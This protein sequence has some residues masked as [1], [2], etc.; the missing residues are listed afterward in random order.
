MTSQKVS[1]DQRTAVL[2]VEVPPEEFKQSLQAAH[3]KNARHFQVP[4]FRKGKAPY[5]VVVRHYGEDI[6]YDDAL[7]IALPKA[8]GQAL[9]EHEIAPF[10]DPRFNVKEISG[11]SGLVFEVSVALKP[12][13]K[14]GKYEGLEAYR[15][16][17]EVEEEAVDRKIEEAR[18]RVSRLVPVTDRPVEE[19]DRVTID[20]K[21]FRGE[22]AF[23][24]GE[25]E[26]HQLEI[27]SGS[28]IPGFE[29]GLIGRSAGDEFDLPLTFPETYQ[30]EDLAGQDVVFKVKIHEILVKELPEIDDEFVR[31][32]SDSCDTVEEY[33]AEIREELSREMNSQADQAFE[34]NI[35]DKIV[36]GSAIELSDLIVEDE[37]DRAIERQE[38]QFAM[39]GLS[40]RDFLQYSGQTP[41][42][43]RAGQARKSRKLIESAWVVETIR[44]SEKERFELSEEEFEKA[45]GEAAEEAGVS[46][47]LFR[48]QYLKSDH[49]EEHLRHD[50]ESRKLLD[51]LREVSL[52]TDVPPEPDE[53]DDHH[54]DHDHDHGHDHHH[55]HDHAHEE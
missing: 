7:E 5:P 35:I 21:G 29:E 3:R 12:E 52:A 48:E 22:Q 25:A 47:E 50:F 43:Y 13:V 2:A 9:E 10:S 54:H 55:G 40:F 19:G 45:V 26:G 15:P 1:E 27:G 44:E 32:V 28:F 36:A 6:L 16:P 8:Y 46:V 38:Q 14:L 39:Y 33:R 34:Q 30:A 42:Q 53:E 17:A 11:Q 31:D 24:G 23:E 41:A 37:I 20:Y 49:D 18:E 4:G 51:W